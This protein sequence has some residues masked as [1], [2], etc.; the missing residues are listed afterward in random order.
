VNLE[1]GKARD[2]AGLGV[3]GEQ[4]I[5]VELAREQDRLGLAG[6]QAGEEMLDRC[7]RRGGIEGAAHQ[8][9]RAGGDPGVNQA[10]QLLV[11]G[12]GDEDLTGVLENIEDA[13]LAQV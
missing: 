9:C 10:C 1:A 6:A 12:G 11:D 13:S 7:G 5:G 2:D 3:V 4:P 8:P